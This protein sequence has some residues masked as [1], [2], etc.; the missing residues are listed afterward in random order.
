MRLQN[1][2]VAHKKGKIPATKTKK[3]LFF[4]NS[5]NS[6]PVVPVAVAVVAAAAAAVASAIAVVD[7]TIDEISPAIDDRGTRF[8]A[9]DDDADDEEVSDCSM[10]DDSFIILP[11]L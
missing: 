7:V 9:D 3:S 8:K 10:G 11:L 5:E 2:T 4:N 1:S 6:I